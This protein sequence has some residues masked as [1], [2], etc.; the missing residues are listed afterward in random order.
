MAK[1]RC[2]FCGNMVL[3]M[4]VHAV[5]S[6]CPICNH[7]REESPP[8]VLEV[9]SEGFCRQKTMGMTSSKLFRVVRG[10]LQFHDKEHKED[11][12]IM[13]GELAELVQEHGVS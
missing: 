2:E 4:D 8:R 10:G 1:W 11:V 7:K 6:T 9:D 13:I 12:V 5:G 3:P